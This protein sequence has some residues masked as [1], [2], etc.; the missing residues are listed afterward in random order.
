MI[1][2]IMEDMTYLLNTIGQDLT[3]NGLTTKGIIKSLNQGDFDDKQIST[4][5]P[6]KRGDIVSFNDIKYLI[7]SESVSTKPIFYKAVMRN[8]NQEVIVKGDKVPIKWDQFGN[9]IEWSDGEDVIVPCFI[10]DDKFLFQDGVINII[11]NDITFTL[12][13]NNSTNNYFKL[14]TVVYILNKS[15]IVKNI[16]EKKNGLLS[17][18]CST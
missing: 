8:L 1:N 18:T 14:N 13:L 12:S 4:N 10:E 16:D 2:N 5:Y 7:I 11:T 6:I 17:I 9:V 15:C 3:I